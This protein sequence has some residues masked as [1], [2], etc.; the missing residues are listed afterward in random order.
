MLIFMTK[1]L[2]S[3]TRLDS[4]ELCRW[5]LLCFDWFFSTNS[6]FQVEHETDFLHFLLFFCYEL[7]FKEWVHFSK[8]TKKST[9]TLKL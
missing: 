2:P 5:V 3:I 8:T 1:T 4:S 7:L 6:C 9:G